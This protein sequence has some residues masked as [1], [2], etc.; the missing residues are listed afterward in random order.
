MKKNGFIATSILYSFFLVFLTL[1][2]A[3]VT[4]YLHNQNL[5]RQVNDEGKD[6]LSHI[7]N[8]HL[9]DLKPGDYIYFKTRSL[10]ESD[11]AG[12]LGVDTS[13]LQNVN[14]LNDNVPWVYAYDDNN[15]YVFISS[16][17]VINENKNVIMSINDFPVSIR[18]S[19]AKAINETVNGNKNGQLRNILGFSVLS[20]NFNYGAD[21]NNIEVSL[22]NLDI[23][24]EFINVVNA[25]QD[26][27]IY[28]SN[29][30]K[31]I[32]ADI[33]DASEIVVVDHGPFDNYDNF[34]Y[35]SVKR[36]VP[37]GTSEEELKQCGINSIDSLSNNN[38]YT[39]GVNI[40]GDLEVKF[41]GFSAKQSN[42]TIDGTFG[43]YVEYCFYSKLQS[44]II[45][46][47]TSN[48]NRLYLKIPKS[49]TDSKI[50]S[51][52]GTMSNPYVFDN[53]K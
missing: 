27:L 24:R 51:G 29:T 19:T 8:F 6:K 23:L 46:G 16:A 7:N 48:G 43:E 12:T 45:P 32:M 50:K 2:L 17:R 36:I 25:D 30:M 31:N 5:I 20:K 9:S 26:K 13:N 42:G 35:Y 18:L 41:I 52:S 14:F 3:L 40:D 44:S 34:T 49:T 10:D 11:F 15:N 37:N 38:L 28:N 22:L 4:N 47:S 39:I 33:D 1:F 53:G 21:H